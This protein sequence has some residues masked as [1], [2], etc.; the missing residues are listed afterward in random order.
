[1]LAC[2]EIGFNPSKKDLPATQKILFIFC[3][4][5]LYE[6]T[7]CCIIQLGLKALASEI[8]HFI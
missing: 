3:F 6:R 8:Y 7:L 5:N 4:Q 1:M 2:Q